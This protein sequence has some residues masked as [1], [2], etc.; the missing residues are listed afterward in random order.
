MIIGITGFLGAGKDTVAEYLMSLGFHHISLSDMIRDELRKKGLSLS[1]ENQQK[2]GNSLREKY[3]SAILAQRALKK[4]S[5]DKNWVVTSIRTPAEVETLK[6]TEKFVLIFV[7]API[8][9]RWERIKARRKEGDPHS[10]SE[11]KTLEERELRGKGSEQQLI[12]VRE[13]AEIILKNDLTIEAL[14]KK[15]DRIIAKLKKKKEFLRPTWDEY[16]LEVMDAV[17]RR[18]TCDRG[19]S[20]AVIV[21]N[22]QILTTGYV[23]S[24]VGIEHCDEVGHLMQTVHHS[25]GSVSKHC[26]RTTHAEQNAICQAAKYGISIDGATLYCKMTPC[27]ACAK[28]IVNSGI[29]RVVCKKAYHRGKDSEELFKKANV[30]LEILDKTPEKYINQ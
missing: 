20:G 22:K 23:G 28:M 14:H 8:R 3:G 12:A 25:D 30:K 9:V 6:Q 27:F 26:V 5:W 13:C 4:M 21:R 19:R 1:R 15:I 7:D 18:A 11:F 24:P 16:F 10:F 29:K 17:A 2:M